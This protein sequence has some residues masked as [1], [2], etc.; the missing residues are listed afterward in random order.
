MVN[1]LLSY[2]NKQF[3][4]KVF[5]EINSN[6]SE[7]KIT[8]KNIKTVSSIEKST[9]RNKQSNSINQNKKLSSSS[10]YLALK[11]ISSYNNKK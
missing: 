10:S 9:S 7:K 6:Y 5:K 3:V 2:N 11:Y 4:K 1:K 8:K